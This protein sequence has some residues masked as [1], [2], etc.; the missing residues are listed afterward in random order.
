MPNRTEAHTMTMI[1]CVRASL[2]RGTFK[3]SVMTEKASKASKTGQS[4]ISVLNMGE[5]THGGHYLCLHP[6]LGLE[7]TCKICD[8]TFSVSCDVWHLSNMIEHMSR[9]EEEDQDQANRCP[10]VSVLDDRED[11]WVCHSRKSEQTEENG[12]C[13]HDPGIVDWSLDGG[14]IAS[15]KMP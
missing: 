12:D 10:Q 1:C 4:S 13:G 6:I 9:S 2:I 11:V 14:V 7:S 8:A 5:L 15:R 3:A